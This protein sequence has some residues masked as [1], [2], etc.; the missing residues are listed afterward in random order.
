[1]SSATD[2]STRNEYS[3]NYW[4]TR[5][6]NHPRF[7]DLFTVA[8]DRQRCTPDEVR[9]SKVW[10]KYLFSKPFAPTTL[11]SYKSRLI[12]IVYC[13]IDDVSLDKI[14]TYDLNREFN[15]IFR[16]EPLIDREELCRRMLELRSVTKETLQLT[17][18]F[19]TNAMGLNEYKIPKLVMLPRDKE[20][21]NIK[22]KEKNLILKEIINS[23]VNCIERKIK[24]LNS[25]YVHDRGLIRGAI[26]FCIMLGTGM[27]IN[28]ARQLSVDDVSKLIKKGEVKSSIH[29]K[30]KNSN[31]NF[32]KVINKKP[33][34]L[35]KE[36][37]V[38]NP[39]ILKISKNTST[40]FKDFKRL[41][42]EAGV[43]VDKPRSNMIRHYLTSNMYNDGMSL[44][45][46]SQMMNHNSVSSTKHYL[47]KFHIGPTINLSDNET[48]DDDD[49]NDEQDH[50]RINT[51]GNNNSSSGSNDDE[52]D[53]ERMEES[54]GADDTS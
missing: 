15:S 7:E 19:Y 28:E 2:G 52:P 8:T 23:V 5:I 40:P 50:N 38:K 37:Y 12:K 25:D 34:E 45:K 17:I 14:D 42:E 35:A 3:F 27:R 54:N 31:F 39:S 16:Q 10:S 49:D 32:I 18:N 30:K 29:L 13:L 48:T 51:D 4:K 11:K 47:N 6:H 9:N 21:K 44:R 22:N 20:L 46:V 41:L 24:Y 36:I 33:L 26:V 1:M 53:D 43:D